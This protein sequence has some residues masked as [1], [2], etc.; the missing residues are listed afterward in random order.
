MNWRDKK[1]SSSAINPKIIVNGNMKTHENDPFFIKKAEESKKIMEKY[2]LPK[3][4]IPEK[5]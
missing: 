4:L 1:S 2:G 5:K 3:E